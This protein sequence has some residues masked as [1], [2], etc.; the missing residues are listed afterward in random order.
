[1]GVVASAAAGAGIK[2][3]EVN[4]ALAT[5]TA[6]GV[7][8]RRAMTAL[9]AIMR[10]ASK[11]SK[12]LDKAFGESASNILRRDGLLG[13]MEKLEEVTGGDTIA[14]QKL[15]IEQEAVTGLAVLA[16]TGIDKFRSSLVAMSEATGSTER[17]YKKMAATFEFQSKKFWN[18]VN[19]V[20]ISIGEEILPFLIEKLE[21]V[22]EWVQEHE[23][24]IKDFV[25]EATN[26]IIEFGKFIL[27]NA[28]T[29]GAAFASI[30]MSSLGPLGKVV[31][32]ITFISTFLNETI[33]KGGLQKRIEAF[34]EAKAALEARDKAAA[35]AEA[36]RLGLDPLVK[37]EGGFTSKILSPEERALLKS[38]AKNKE[39]KDKEKKE[40]ANADTIKKWIKLREAALDTLHKLERGLMDELTQMRINHQDELL[41]LMAMRGLSEEERERAL[42]LLRKKYRK[43]EHNLI[44]KLQFKRETREAEFIKKWRPFMLAMAGGAMGAGKPTLPDWLMGGIP[45]GGARETIESLARKRAYTPGAIT[46]EELETEEEKRKY[47]FADGKAEPDFWDKVATG[48]SEAVGARLESL[49]MD[50]VGAVTKPVGQIGDLFGM[51][52]GGATVEDVKGQAEQMVQFWEALA[53]NIG[54]VLDYLVEDGIP[55]IIDAFVEHI[56]DIIDAIT[57]AI[58]DIIAAVINRVPDIALALAEAVAKAIGNLLTF[59]GGMELTQKWGEA[60][61]ILGHAAGFVADVGKG[62][63]DWIGSWFHEGGFVKAINTMNHSAGVFAG[64]IK[65]HSGLFVRPGLSAG[66]VPAIL[67]TGEGVIRKEIV[68]AMGGEPFVDALNQ[69]KVGGNGDTHVHLHTEHLY[70]SDAAEVVDDLQSEMIRRGS[71]RMRRI[72][73]GD[74]MPGF[75]PRRA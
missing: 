35:E 47:A 61:P 27:A 23:E 46:G 49:M 1:L 39:K 28:K 31:A 65:A 57:E 53:E 25:K 10:V 54:P 5:M 36:K 42:S 7:P 69:G 4:A 15:N 13:V 45:L 8:P 21:E 51:A 68:A 14:L 71:G 26:S 24:D 17:A 60:V 20:F 56:P 34:P 29:I 72:I 50:V 22:A 30:W 33:P 63:V 3:G 6:A 58:P 18:I 12:E 9:N 64:A 66:D 32:A 55:M 40:K 37:T 62:I 41:K 44:Q 43:D 16:G 2:F 59:G 67:Q 74:M 48:F 38:S 73:S 11:G 70:A 19:E 52:M 75:Q